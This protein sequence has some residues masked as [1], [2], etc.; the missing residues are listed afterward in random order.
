MENPYVMDYIKPEFR[1][2]P[3]TGAS[4]KEKNIGTEVLEKYN[5]LGRDA[6]HDQIEVVM[7]NKQEVTQFE[8]RL[9][10]HIAE[11]Y[12]SSI[13]GT[14]SAIENNN[15][16]YLDLEELYTT[17]QVLSKE[18]KWLY[19][20]RL[21][22]RHIINEHNA[23]KNRVDSDDLEESLDEAMEE[24]SQNF[25]LYASDPDAISALD[26]NVVQSVAY[27]NNPVYHR[28][29]YDKL[30]KKAEQSYRSKITGQPIEV[31][32]LSG[33]I[34][35]E[36][37]L[38]DVRPDQYDVNPAKLFNKEQLQQYNE[39][40]GK[41]VDQTL[42]LM[43][44]SDAKVIADDIKMDDLQMSWLRENHPDMKI[45]LDEIDEVYINRA[46][47][48]AKGKNPVDSISPNWGIRG[49]GDV[50]PQN[51]INSSNFVAKVLYYHGLAFML[52][53]ILVAVLSLAFV[54]AHLIKDTIFA[55]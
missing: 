21:K 12:V 27:A 31:K 14:F 11:D 4:T 24:S 36:K 22:R 17:L 35:V 40:M 38:D 19:N 23:K 15:Y 28:V 43:A 39:L 34:Q 10:G 8:E 1:I 47:Y 45:L 9:L 42:S 44:L 3:Y 6:K 7:L 53:L 37:I 41:P 50:R 26:T 2:D 16:G 46:D 33:N 18:N 25:D 29:V 13:R 55:N 54:G 5:A 51:E 48:R 49:E 30:I 32:T 20:G 52:S